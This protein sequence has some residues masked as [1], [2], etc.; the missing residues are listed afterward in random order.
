MV[1]IQKS[2]DKGNIYIGKIDNVKLQSLCNMIVHD[3]KSIILKTT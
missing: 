3:Y 2:K 1:H